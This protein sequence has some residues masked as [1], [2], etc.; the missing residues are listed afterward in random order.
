[1]VFLPDFNYEGIAAPFQNRTDV[2]NSSGAACAK[3]RGFQ[4]PVKLP[5]AYTKKTII[6]C[7]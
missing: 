6:E 7:P 3:V 1:M 4:C 5:G 2:A